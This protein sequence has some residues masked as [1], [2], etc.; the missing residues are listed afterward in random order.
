MLSNFNETII[1][2]YSPIASKGGKQSIHRRANKSKRT[3]RKYKKI[4]AHSK[5]K[6]TRR[7]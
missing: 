2:Q 3:Y 7:R 4:K 6:R 5:N 1:S